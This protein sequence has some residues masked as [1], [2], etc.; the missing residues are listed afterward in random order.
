MNLGLDDRTAI[1]GGASAGIGVAIAKAL[2]DEGAN[3]V[4]FSNEPDELAR[5]AEEVGGIAVAGDQRV[6][7]DLERLVG[8]TVETFGAIDV[9][10]LNGGGPEAVSAVAVN[11]NDIHEG[12]SLMLLPVVRLTRMCLPHLSESPLGRILAIVS[13]SVFEPID[14]LA[15]SNMFR[16]AVLGWLKTLAREVGSSGITV[17]A[18]APGRIATR[19]F[20]EFY[21]DRSMEEDL[22]A[23]PLGRFGEPSEVGDLVCFLASERA[24]YLSGTVIPIDGGL[25]RSLT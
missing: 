3:V 4:M 19:T 22:G 25:T 14:D 1:V 8:V 5:R 20:Q 10:V 2:R 6:D 21:K 17:N 13:T 11:D 18:I 7:A 9:V 12:L 24:A 15:L 16:P 23:I